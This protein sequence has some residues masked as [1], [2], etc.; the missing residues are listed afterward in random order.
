MVKIENNSNETLANK[1]TFSKEIKLK[2]VKK[3]ASLLESS[4]SHGIPNIIRTNRISI[5]VLWSV[6]V[7]AALAGCSFM[8]IKSVTDYLEYDTVSKTEFITEI[9][10]QFP[11]FSFCNINPLITNA[12]VKIVEDLLPIYGYNKTAVITSFTVLST[13]F[14]LA[15][16]H[17]LLNAADPSFGDEKRKKLGYNLAD[18]LLTC[19]YNGE[20]CNVDEFEWY[21]DLNLGNCFRFN[22]GRDFYR[23]RTKLKESV[24][25]GPKN[26]LTIQFYLKPSE[27]KYSSFFSEGFRVFVHNNSIIPSFSEGVNV[28]PSKIT[29]ITIQRTFIQCCRN[30]SL[31]NKII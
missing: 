4:T 24:K 8:V 29:D 31:R 27:N 9:P 2:V 15:N 30:I 21:F 6:C 1:K 12:S 18:Y 25:A 13:I 26:G 17:V 3:V 20:E 28:E 7:L 5:K 10:T 16:A 22:S 19:S 11:T 14:E 23:N